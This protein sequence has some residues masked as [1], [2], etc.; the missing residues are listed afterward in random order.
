M[1]DLNVTIIILGAGLEVRFLHT[2][3]FRELATSL[4]VKTVLN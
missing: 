4:S 1:K 2:K 3:E